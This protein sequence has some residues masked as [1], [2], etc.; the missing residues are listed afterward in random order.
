[1]TY[2]PTSTTTTID[3]IPAHF[4]CN[5]HVVGGYRPVGMSWGWYAKST[6]SWHNETV[7]AAT[8]FVGL[9][10]FLDALERAVGRW[11]VGDAWCDGAFSLVV[12]RACT[13]MMFACST[14][15]HAFWPRGR[16]AYEFL[17]R[18]DHGCIVLCV[19]SYAFPTAAIVSG[20]S[21]FATRLY[22]IAAIVV[23]VRNVA[24]VTTRRLDTTTRLRATVA[25][26]WFVPVLYAHCLSRSTKD[27]DAPDAPDAPEADDASSF[28]AYRRAIVAGTAYPIGAL[29]YAT[30][31]PDRLRPGWFDHVG[32]HEF[33]HACVLFAALFH[34]HL[35]ESALWR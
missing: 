7:N 16:R 24:L 8:M 31:F 10:F 17:L 14:A 15:Y 9:V 20:A 30:R 4:E 19:G 2:R 18:L 6:L 26:A 12:F 1:M 34:G 32:S 23:T 25:T 21:T 28:E 27:D 5:P 29:A 13:A 35:F 33:M 11:Y 22:W 3:A